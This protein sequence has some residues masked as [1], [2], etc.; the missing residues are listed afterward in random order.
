MFVNFFSSMK[1][2]MIKKDSVQNFE[3]SFLQYY[4]PSYK[5]LFFCNLKQAIITAELNCYQER[6]YNDGLYVVIEALHSELEVT[7]KIA[8]K[9]YQ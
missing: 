1:E 7:M 9:R 8:G 4:S 3:C 5:I 2:G 6:N